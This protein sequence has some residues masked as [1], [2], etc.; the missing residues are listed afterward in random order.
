MGQDWGGCPVSYQGQCAGFVGVDAPDGPVAH[1]E[2]TV[3]NEDASVLKGG[4]NIRL[5]DGNIQ[6]AS[7]KVHHPDGH[8]A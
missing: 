4:V 8:G 5:M 6:L 1:D 2:E 3:Q 7:G